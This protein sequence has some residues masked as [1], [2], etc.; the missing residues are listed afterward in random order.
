ER[1]LAEQ[2]AREA[3]ERIERLTADAV[4]SIDRSGRLQ[5]WNHGAEQLF[6]WSKEEALGEALPLVPEQL[7]PRATA[8]VLGIIDD[9][10][11]ISKETV[12]LTK[13]GREIPVLGSW[14]PVPLEDG[15]IGVLCILK[16]ITAHKQAHAQL[17]EQARSLALL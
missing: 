6:G 12:R 7:Q 10:N 3:A 16:D 2:S 11:P 14:S 13:D 15:S 17:Q 5:S 8:D 9:G 1:W 4:Y